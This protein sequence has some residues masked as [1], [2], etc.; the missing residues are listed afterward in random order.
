MG[1][2]PRT[3]GWM[4][5]ALPAL[6]AL[7]ALAL[8]PRSAIAQGQPP[9]PAAPK[10]EATS[11]SVDTKAAL[12]AV[13]KILG[14]VGLGVSVK[15]TRDSILRDNPRADQVV[16]VLTMANSY[17]LMIWSDTSLSPADKQARFQAAMQDMLSRALGPTPVAR[18][19]TPKQSR[20]DGRNLPGAAPFAGAAALKFIAND[21]VSDAL[22]KPQTGFLRDAPFY[23]TDANRHFVIVGSART[24]EE[25][26]QLMNRFKSKAPQHDFVVYGPYGSNTYFGVVMATWVPRDVAVEAQRLARRD[27][28]ADAYIWSCRG[29]GESC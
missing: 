19:D 25:G 14:K 27:V 4:S 18:T 10:L 22:P 11:T 12:D 8:G 24:Q 9:C 15:T 28:A 29:S 5:T 23:V 26:I 17:C 6:A 1:R 20:L 2:R 21:G 7:A 13:A 16:I 3:L